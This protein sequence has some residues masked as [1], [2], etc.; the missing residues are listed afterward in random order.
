MAQLV[1][2]H[3]G[4]VGVRGSSPLSSTRM[5]RSGKSYSSPT[6]LK[7]GLSVTL[8]SLNRSKASSARRFSGAEIALSM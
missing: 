2:H 3:T 8:V 5:G 1:A 7:F 6:S 4:S